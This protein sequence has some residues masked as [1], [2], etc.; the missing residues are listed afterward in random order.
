MPLYKCLIAFVEILLDVPYNNFPPCVP[1]FKPM[2][3]SCPVFIFWPLAFN[4]NNILCKNVIYPFIFLLQQHIKPQPNYIFFFL[5]DLSFPIS[6]LLNSYG[7][8]YYCCKHL[9]TCYTLGF[10]PIIGLSCAAYPLSF[11]LRGAIAPV[12]FEPFI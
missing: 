9:L 5:Q 7:K 12:P 1:L 3:Y 2:L 4:V 11:S 6:N 10:L 8:V